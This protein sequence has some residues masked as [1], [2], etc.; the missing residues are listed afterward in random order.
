MKIIFLVINVILLCLISCSYYSK[1][2]ERKNLN[3]CT[4]YKCQK[5]LILIQ[6]NSNQIQKSQQNNSVITPSE[7]KKFAVLKLS[8][9][10]DVQYYGD[11]YIGI[12]KK[13][14]TVIFDT[15]SNILWVPSNQCT[16]CRK[17]S[18]RYNP[19]VSKTSEKINKSNSI[20][21]AV[22]FVEGEIYSETVSLNSYESFL[23]SFNNELIAEKYKFL[24]VNK[25]MNLTGTISDGVMGLGIYNEGDP[26]NSFIET[27][28]NQKQINEPSFSFYLFGVK[29]ISRLYIG[30]ILNNVYISKLFNNNKQECFV[31]KNDLFWECYPYNGIKLINNNSDKIKTFN[32][33]SSII[34][35]TGS[36]Y[37]LI[38]KPDFMI[39]FNFLKLEHNCI[40][41]GENQL[42][43]QCSS[44]NEFGKIELNFDN[45]NKFVINL[46]NMIEFYRNSKYQCQFQI[47]MEIYD[48]NTWI[49]GDSSLRRN[50]ISFNMYERK[51]SFIQ[52]I[53]GIIEDTKIGQSSWINK[54]GSLLYSFVFWFIIL[55]TIGL[56][57]L[58]ILYLFR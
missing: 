14:M 53:S 21:F 40:I 35:D 6:E 58:F 34:F 9:R 42:L 43:C 56:I 24:S 10:N 20:A 46:N 48:L 31:G 36:S 30:D 50:L 47:T 12:P 27:L 49:L 16:T 13:K 45:K 4:N 57:I 3:N 1:S 44:K 55:V 28:Y 54:S 23:K 52:N 15:G 5:Q 38:P 29:N 41:S 7:T 22:G 18:V 33:N 26:Y 32:T 8:N 19:I 39:I 11:I 2:I 51:I 25:E 37:T 17:D